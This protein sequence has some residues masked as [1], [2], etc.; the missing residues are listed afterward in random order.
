MGDSHLSGPQEQPLESGG[1]LPYR[2]AGDQATVRVVVGARRHRPPRPVP[3]LRLRCGTADPGAVRVLRP[4]RWRGHRGIHDR[5][6][7]VIQPLRRALRLSP[8]HHWR[9]RPLRRW[10][11]RSGLHQRRAAAHGAQ[12]RAALHRRVRAGAHRGRGGR[13]RGPELLC[14]ARAAARRGASRRHR[15]G[16]GSTARHGAGQPGR[17]RCPR[18][19][20]GSGPLAMA[21]YPAPDPPGQPLA[22]RP[23]G[24]G[25]SRSTTAE[26]QCRA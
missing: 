23:T 7:R 6:G 3:R 11:L 9:P 22:E 24:P 17:P 16:V 18:D 2:R 19:Q 4:V 8:Q 25:S 26:R 10:H 15:A 5:A 12:V 14:P 20:P 1:V 21:R 13:V